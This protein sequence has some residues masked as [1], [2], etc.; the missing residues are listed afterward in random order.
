MHGRDFSDLF[1][2]MGC[3]PGGYDI[4]LE[5][6]SVSCAELYKEDSACSG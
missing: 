3:L 2:G 5:E 1:Q 6:G 4:E